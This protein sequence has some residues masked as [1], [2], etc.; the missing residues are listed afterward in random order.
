MKILFLTIS[1]SEKNHISFY[2]ELLQEFINKGHDVYVA[3]ASEKRKGVE[4]HVLKERN[5]N[6][7][8]IKTGNIT[9]NISIFEKGIST[10]LID[11]LFK[12]AIKKYYKNEKFD[13]VLYPT[14]PI[15]LVNTVK[16]LKNKKEVKTYLLLKDIF[17][18]NAVDLGMLSKKGVKSPLY[19]MFREKEKKLY[20][21]SD[22]IGCMSQANVNYVIENNKNISK[23]KIEVCP[24]SVKPLQFEKDKS[25][26]DR[27]GISNDKV[28]FI[29]GGNLGKP[30]GIDF[31]K[32]CLNKCKDIEKAYFLII[33]GGSEAQSIKSFI[34]KNKIGNVKYIETLPKDEY[35]KLA[36][37]C[38]VGLVFLDYRFTIPNF[39][40]RILSYMQTSIPVLAATDSTT[41]MGKIIEDNNFGWWCESNDVKAFYECVE[42]AIKSNRLEMGKNARKYLEKYYD[43]KC[44]YEII[45]KHF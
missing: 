7:L 39:P 38:D 21:I 26:R 25:V 3:C 5:I 36:G 20:E 9:G 33:G 10:L 44:S 32:E 30:Q 18:Q 14:P 43:V 23:E 35:E 2:E 15:T 41:D 29:Y 11:I 28:T 1:F 31:I 6:I 27:Y 37:N 24:N 34:N 13:L 45:M 4:T 17:P 40:S 8:R 12:N 19:Y 16:W 22:Y 42:K